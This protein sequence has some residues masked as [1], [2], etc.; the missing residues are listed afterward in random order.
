MPPN[1]VHAPCIATHIKHTYDRV[2]GHLMPA[3][4]PTRI[5]LLRGNHETRQI[6]QVYG[7]Y[8]ELEWQ[9]LWGRAVVM[10]VQKVTSWWLSCKARATRC[11]MCG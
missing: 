2:H 11:L 1:L 6:T 9:S 8:G 4:Y 10:V 3:R 7:F 5:A